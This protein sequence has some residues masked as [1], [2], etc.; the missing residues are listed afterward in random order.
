VAS[1]VEVIWSCLELDEIRCLE[2]DEIRCLE[3]DEIN[4]AAT[5]AQLN[6]QPTLDALGY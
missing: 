4:V 3:L 5:R 6:N 1:I 2:L